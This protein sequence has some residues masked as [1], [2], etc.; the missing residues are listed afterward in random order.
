MNAV[1]R[2]CVCSAL[3]LGVVLLTTG[4][5]QGPIGGIPQLN[6]RHIDEPSAGGMII[7]KKKKKKNSQKSNAEKFVYKACFVMFSSDLIEESTL[8]LSWE[9]GKTL[10][11]LKRIKDGTFTGSI[12]ENGENIT[13]KI[14]LTTFPEPS[15]LD[16]KK[17]DKLNLDLSYIFPDGSLMT[18]GAQ[19]FEETGKDTL[20]FKSMIML[21]R[22][23]R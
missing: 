16:S 15:T 11:S 23:A 3:M 1:S 10:T 20:V 17:V 14:V 5:S 22:N 19:D 21:M 4:W 8:T 18:F 9:N 13:A 12:V 6:E 2:F 7:A